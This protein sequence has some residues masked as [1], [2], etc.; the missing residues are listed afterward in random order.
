MIVCPGC[1]RIRVSE[2][3][4]DSGRGELWAKP[5]RPPRMRP[6][7]H[8]EPVRYDILDTAEGK[9]CILCR[10]SQ[11]RTREEPEG[12]AP[13]DRDTAHRVI[14]ILKTIPPKRRLAVIRGAADQL[15][16]TLPK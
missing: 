6:L 2:P 10:E 7:K 1:G 8:H 16:V 3:I 5:V 15:G 4:N 12:V 13:M 11:A 14:G 9:H